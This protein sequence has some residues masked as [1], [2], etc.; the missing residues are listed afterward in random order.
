MILN[1]MLVME[2]YGM[3]YIKM[4][5]TILIIMLAL[6]L[7]GI[8]TAGI[9]ISGLNKQRSLEKEQRDIL[10]SKT[11]LGEINPN[12]EV[13]CLNNYCL[14]SASQEGIIS[15]ESNSIQ[16]YWMNCTF[17]NETIRECEIE[18]RI[19]YTDDEIQDIVADAVLNKLKNYA[20]AEIS[21]EIYEDL[22]TGNIEIIE[23]I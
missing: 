23:L 18:E 15:S 6:L 1:F 8:V 16:R 4:K 19:D 11:D 2:H 21:R 20:D 12:V 5:K 13:R 10:L 14:W 17:F 7:I 9:G 22:I 3:D